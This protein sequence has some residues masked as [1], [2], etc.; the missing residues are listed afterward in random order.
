V[1]S[2]I[3][4]RH[5]SIKFIIGKMLTTA[6]SSCVFEKPLVAGTGVFLKADISTSISGVNTYIDVR[7]TSTGQP[8]Q[9]G[10]HMRCSGEAQG[11][12]IQGGHEAFAWLPRNSFLLSWKR[13]V[14]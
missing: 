11:G 12:E 8:R 3:I 13:M 9:M 6:G 14:A 5:D 2:N 10:L 7:L 1:H 4:R